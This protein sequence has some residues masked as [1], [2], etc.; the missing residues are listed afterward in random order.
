MSREFSKLNGHPCCY[1]GIQMTRAGSPAQPN[2][3]TRDHVVSVHAGGSGQKTVRCCRQCNED[4]VHYSINEW[5]AALCWRH[6]R[7]HLFYFER[8]AFRVLCVQAGVVAHS[9]LRSAGF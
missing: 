9:L 1:C 7:L 3:A 2:F 8:L 5:R 4:K 6:K